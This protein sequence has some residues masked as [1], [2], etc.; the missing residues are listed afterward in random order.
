MSLG[1][2]A[3]YDLITGFK[4][5]FLTGLSGDCQFS[6]ASSN[7]AAFPASVS[8]SSINTL[9][10][11]F[12]FQCIRIFVFLSYCRLIVGKKRSNLGTVPLAGLRSWKFYL[13]KK[14]SRQKEK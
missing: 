8:P 13:H 4:G 5:C 12:R 9:K 3:C 1:L 6:P 10:I 2:W 14:V 7:K 11:L